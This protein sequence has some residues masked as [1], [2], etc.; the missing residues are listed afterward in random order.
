MCAYVFVRADMSACIRAL[1]SVCVRAKGTFQINICETKNLIEAEG[2]PAEKHHVVTKDG[3]I[4]EMHRIPFGK[5]SPNS[6]NRPVVFLMHGILGASNSFIYLGP[7]YSIAYNLADAGY[8]VWMG[9][10]RGTRNSRQH[11]SLNPDRNKSFFDFTFEEI[12]LDDLPSMFDYM[13]AHTGQ[14][15][16][17]YI[18]HS[19]GGTVFLVLNSMSSAYHSK[20]ASAHLLAGVGY[21]KNFPNYSLR[22]L[23]LSADAL[24]SVLW[25]GG[26]VELYPPGSTAMFG[27]SGSRG[28]IDDLFGIDTSSG[29]IAG[30]ATKQIVHFGQNIRDK[31]FRRWDYGYVQNLV[32]YGKL[33]PTSYDLSKINI[34]VTLHYSLND[35]LL[36]ESDVLLMAKDMPKATAR[37]ISRDSFTHLDYVTSKDVKVLLNDYII[38]ALRNS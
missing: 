27:K 6:R 3:Y 1:T 10:A 29:L 2:Y 17:H 23:A 4:L 22:T 11:V 18:G 34:D 31:A 12:A 14:Q 19:Q 24:Y 28:S 37:K 25:L 7:E 30:A 36:S 21:Q 15:K 9:N 20:I 8:D 26:S 13:L 16:F 5:S 32:K 33:S 38:Q 35:A